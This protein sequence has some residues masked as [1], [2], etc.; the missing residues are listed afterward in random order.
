MFLRFGGCAAACEHCDT[1]RARTQLS[2]FTL[3]GTRAEVI[4]NPIKVAD[5]AAL[6]QPLLKAV[7]FI[8]ITG[9]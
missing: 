7:R 3:H 9:G 1:P 2:Q 4:P 6:L 5:L 8:G